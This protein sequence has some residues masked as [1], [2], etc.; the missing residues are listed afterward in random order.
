MFSCHPVI[1]ANNHIVIDDEQH[2]IIDTGS[3][4]SFHATGVMNLCGE[5]IPVSRSIPHVSKEYLSV[6]VGM[7]ID[8]LLGMDL[9]NQHCLTISLKDD[10]IM[11][12]DE[13]HFTHSFCCRE[14]GPE[15]GGLIV[16]RIVVNGRPA[17]VFVDTGAPISYIHPSY[18]EGL[19]SDGIMTDFSPFIGD[20]QTSIYTCE[21]D[22]LVGEKP[23]TQKFGTPPDI[24]A[25]TMNQF[26]VD[27]VIGVDLFRQYRIQIREGMLYLPPQGI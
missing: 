13:T 5:T 21:V 25:M 15:Y 1:L 23:Y 7:T 26:N 16:I 18:T 14:T 22:A 4:V 27:G 6:K 3:P 9:I 20:F 24:V 10:F 2:I 19:K 17:K 11:L 8:G 12:D